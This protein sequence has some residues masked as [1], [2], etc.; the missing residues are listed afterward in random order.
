MIADIVRLA[1]LQLTDWFTRVGSVMF[2]VRPQPAPLVDG[3]ELNGE[4]VIEIA[5]FDRRIA[6]KEPHER[7]EFLFGAAQYPNE[8]PAGRNRVGPLHCRS[9]INDIAAPRIILPV[10]G[11]ARKGCISVVHNPEFSGQRRR[12]PL[13]CCPPC[14]AYVPAMASPR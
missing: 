12:C 6:P 14:S 4:D 11:C 7:R 8:E 3:V 5:E 1:G 13:L 9:P 10:P 2:F